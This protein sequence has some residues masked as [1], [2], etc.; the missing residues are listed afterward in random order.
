MPNEQDDA[1][2]ADWSRMLFDTQKTTRMEEVDTMARTR[3]QYLNSIG[4]AIR[5]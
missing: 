5:Q 4:L 2:N 1:G 3:C